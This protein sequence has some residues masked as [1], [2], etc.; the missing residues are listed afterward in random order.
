MKSLYLSLLLSLLISVGYTQ[1]VTSYKRVA[2]VYFQNKEYFAAAEYYKKALQLS[3]D[4]VSGF[5]VPY[6]FEAR[7]KQQG[8][9]KKQDYAYLVFQL[10]TSLRLYHNFRDAEHWYAI[11]REFPEPAYELSAFW[12]ASCLRANQKFSEAVVAFNAFVAQYKRNDGY[13]S[14]AQ[15]E[16]QSCHFALNELRYPRLYTIRR[17][18]NPVNEKGSNYAPYVQGDQFYFTSSRPVNVEGKMEVLHDAAQRTKVTRKETPYLH[19]IYQLNG[20]PLSSSG[21]V[22]KLMEN[23]KGVETAAAVIHPNGQRMYVTRWGSREGSKNYRIYSASRTVDGWSDFTPLG[24][25][26]NYAGFNSMQPFI[27]SDGRFLLYS[28]DRPGGYGKYDLWYCRLNPDGSPGVGINLGAT[29]NTEEDD[30][31]PFYHSLTK[32]L[33]Y[34]T[35]GRIGMG[36]FDFFESE[37]DFSQWKEPVNLGYPFNSSKDDLYYTPLDGQG[38]KVYISSDR[39]SVCCLEVLLVERTYLHVKGQ[40]TDCDTWK[41][42]EGA[43]VVLEDSSGRQETLTDAKGVYHFRTRTNR[44]L[45]LTAG[46]DNY[47]SKVL[48]YRYDELVNI[49]TLVNPQWCL[50][51]F[52]VDKPIVLENVLYAF[53]S[54]ELTEESKLILDHLYQVMTVNEHIEIE[55]SAHTDN[56]GSAAYNMN[57]SDRRAKSCVDYLIGKGI[58]SQRMTSR[59]YG[60][61]RPIA[62]NQGI[63]GK[64]NP[65]GRQLN[66]RTEF[67]V[68][69]K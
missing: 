47:F 32:K 54:H 51:A 25:E 17:L 35:K 67:K 50:Q 42:L 58:S 23:P 1:Q 63:D 46:K 21:T 57:L 5:V 38:D 4:S 49:D 48:H 31:A 34:S 41:P 43:L 11:A 36:G 8:K 10:A 15:M 18:T 44:G 37:G 6:G 33:R 69:K 24:G 3:G 55:L 9:E 13:V 64:D 53:D 12:Y 66:R 29:I 45:K 52:E 40:L 28:S 27:T 26:V 59:G 14:K 7:M 19:H 61:T 62:P 30:Q 65:E 68:T 39:S 20:N 60:F 16:L 2:D 56:I 22:Q